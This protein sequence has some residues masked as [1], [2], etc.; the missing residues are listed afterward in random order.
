MSTVASGAGGV[1]WL[2]VQFV[3]QSA[4]GGGDGRFGPWVIPPSAQLTV[5]IDMISRQVPT[6][7]LGFDIF[8]FPSYVGDRRIKTKA[9]AVVV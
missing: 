8:D 1:V 9:N 6:T 7:C 5:A 2:L 4:G 3:V